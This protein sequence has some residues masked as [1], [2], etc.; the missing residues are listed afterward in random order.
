MRTWQFQEPIWDDAGNITDGVNTLT[1][2]DAEILAQYG[3]YW[4]GRMA[5]LGRVG[6][7]EMCI[8]DFVTSNWARE[9]PIAPATK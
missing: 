8:Q 2:T 9:I 1:F 4:Y 5:A 7:D 6:T 3:P